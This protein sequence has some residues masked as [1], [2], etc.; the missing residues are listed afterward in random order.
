MSN[1]V[2]K[3]IEIYKDY[4]G[5]E[6]HFQDSYMGHYEDKFDSPHK[7]P[8]HAYVDQ[9]AEDMGWYDKVPQPSYIDLDAFVRDLKASGWYHEDG[10][11]FRPV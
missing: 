1:T 8:L 10:H 2:D 4:N 9:Y 7:S 3:A 11:V 6:E 5:T